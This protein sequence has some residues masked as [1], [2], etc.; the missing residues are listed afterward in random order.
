M[1]LQPTN[2]RFRRAVRGFYAWSGATLIAGLAPIAALRLIDT[3]TLAGRIGGVVLGTAGWAPLAVVITAIIR[4]GDEFE[5]RIHLIALALS[6]ASA[7]VLL[8]L[9][10][11]LARAEFIWP[12]PLRLIWLAFC[13]LWLI[14]IVLVKRHFA[15]RS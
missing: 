3:G 13:V 4:A 7:L 15:P 11:W 2:L 9:L 6:F 5:R 10:D 8:A 1:L 12:P 14:W